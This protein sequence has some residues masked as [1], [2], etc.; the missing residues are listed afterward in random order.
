MTLASTS[1]NLSDQL[2]ALAS[3]YRG[4]GPRYT[5]YPTS[6]H[7]REDFSFE[8]LEKAV[9]IL[10]VE[11]H[12]QPLSVYTH[13]PFCESICYYCACNKVVTGK[14]RF[15][16]R[17]LSALSK[18]LD[19]YQ[20]WDLNKRPV[21]QLH[22][23]GGTPTY[24]SASEM[25]ELMHLLAQR[26]VLVSDPDREYSIE[27]DPRT[28][29]GRIIALL[30]G[31]G[32]NRLSLGIQDFD[33][34]V[35]KAINRVQPYE[36]VQEL[37]KEARAHDFVSLSFDLIYGLPHQNVKSFTKTLEQVVSLS[38]DRIACYN[39]AHLPHRFLAQRAIDRLTL[40]NSEQ[41]LKLQQHIDAILRGSGYELVGLDHYVKKHDP[42]ATARNDNTLQRN[43]Q[44]YSLKKAS[45]MIGLGH[46]AISQ[47]G[48]LMV[49]NEVKLERYYDR[50]ESGNN[51]LYRGLLLSK[52]DMLRR[53]V[54]MEICCS[55]EFSPKAV[56]KKYGQDAESYF[57]EELKQMHEFEKDG[58][59]YSNNEVFTLT[60]IGR[61]FLRQICMTFDAWLK[62]T[63]SN[64]KYSKI[65]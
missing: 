54:I 1:T 46:S 32:F 4:E 24:L 5:S 64:I 37:V 36:R 23:G 8:T 11:Q 42:L 55:L 44:G 13:I 25:T 40:P 20:T 19:I 15:A 61:H 12:N 28:V 34:K 29:D 26:Y 49:Q 27:I 17:Y 38:P 47:V 3:K 22:W 58:L 45:D 6:P 16:T 56:C 31:L 60:Q 33:P 65:I 63:P 57:K 59:V 30:K 35:Q 48:P 14:K 18:E 41:R 39:Y 52:D 10:P 62:F 2:L 9:K 21:T 50:I 7:M 53:E 51:A 43:F